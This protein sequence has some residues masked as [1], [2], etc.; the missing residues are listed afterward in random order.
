MDKH[1]LNLSLY[2]VTDP[3]LSG[4]LPLK[5]VVE[6]AIA[7]GAACV[8]LRDKEGTIGELFQT[9]IEILEIT[10]KHSIPL[11][12]NDRL[13]IALA[14]KA[15][16]VHLGQEDLPAAAARRIMPREMILGVSV[17]SVEQAVEAQA[18]GASYLGV[19]PI[20][21]TTTKT[22]AG[23]PIELSILTKICSQVHIPVVGIGGI[24]SDNAGLVITAGAQGV[25]VVSSVVG[26]G[27]VKGAAEKVYLAV[28][29]A[30]S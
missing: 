12:I 20:F 13:D 25:A 27:D 18:A 28:S 15:D 11:I 16:G 2:V 9:A 17:D 8:Q 23:A 3:F 5:I 6:Q 30:L 24:N 22:D 1:K 10:K 26:A 21:S 7:G 14:I 19:G 4:S 29:K